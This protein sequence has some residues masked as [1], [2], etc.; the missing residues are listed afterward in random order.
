MNDRLPPSSF[1]WFNRLAVGVSGFGITALSLLVMASQLRGDGDLLLGLFSLIPLAIGSFC[2]WFSIVHRVRTRAELDS[3]DV[4][5]PPHLSDDA[6]TC[7]F[8][9][10]AGGVKSVSVDFARTS[11]HFQNCHMPRRFLA[12]V[13]SE[14]T[15]SFADLIAVH[16][17]RYR[18]DSLTIQT[19][20]GKAIIPSTATEYERLCGLLPDCVPPNRSGV[21]TER[22]WMGYVYA[23]SAMGGLLLALPLVPRDASIGVVALSMFLGAGAGI[24]VAR[25]AAMILQAW[26]TRPKSMADVGPR[27]SQIRGASDGSRD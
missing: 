11:I 14:F 7:R 21:V 13:D 18:G 25:A 1:P 26:L 9:G 23:L 8:A 27:R 22:P 4:A 24:F 5:P 20:T 19:T 10:L 12:L 3:L 6:L 16:R 2:V 15:C 17:F